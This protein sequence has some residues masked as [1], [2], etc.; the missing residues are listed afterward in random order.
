MATWRDHHQY[1]PEDLAWLAKASRK[2][3][4]LVITE[5]DA[6]KLRDRWPAGVAE[7]LV[8]QLDLAWEGGGEGFVAALDSVVALTRSQLTR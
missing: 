6:V 5:K 2:S 3:D 4:H 1:G 7:P 8:A